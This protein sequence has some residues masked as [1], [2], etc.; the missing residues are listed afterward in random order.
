LNS[1]VSEGVVFTLGTNAESA[2]ENP[3]VKLIMSLA[4]KTPCKHGLWA[5]RIVAR[6][7]SEGLH[8]K[9]DHRFKKIQAGSQKDARP[10]TIGR[11][12]FVPLDG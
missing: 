11:W 5:I 9:F 1:A 4:V 6:T 3:K 2:R 10:F 7:T 12:L 8:K